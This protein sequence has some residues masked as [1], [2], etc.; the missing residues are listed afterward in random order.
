MA[1]ILIIEDDNL[2]SKLYSKIFKFEQYEVVTALNGA[3]GLEMAKLHKPTL[4]LLDIMMPEM[5][6]LEVLD[7]LKADN[8]LKAI[9]VVVLTNLAGSQ[10]AESAMTK[11][12]VRYIIKSEHDPKEVANMVKEIVLGHSRAKDPSDMAVA[13]QP[14]SP[15]VPAPPQAPVSAPPQR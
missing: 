14:V 10:D 5:N 3:E 11:G 4:I 15:Q 7:K 2:M 8:E 13:S 12:A 1:K 9:P 6:G